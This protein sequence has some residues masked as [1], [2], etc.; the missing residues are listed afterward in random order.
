MYQFKNRKLETD[1]HRI[2]SFSLISF[3]ESARENILEENRQAKLLS[4]TQLFTVTASD[5]VR[6]QLM[7]Q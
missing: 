5:F 6:E 7:N 1:N 3:D 4:R 2:Y